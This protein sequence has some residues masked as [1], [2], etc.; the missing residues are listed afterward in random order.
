VQDI[1]SFE[2]DEFVRYVIT[3]VNDVV[4]KKGI[5][6]GENCRRLHLLVDHNHLLQTH[7]HLLTE[8]WKQKQIS[9]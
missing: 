5:G 4:K 1:C 2:E 9:H 7:H 8:F 3:E 6:F